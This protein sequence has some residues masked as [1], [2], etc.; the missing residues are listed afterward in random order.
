M[1]VLKLTEKDAI[2]I[3]EMH[4]LGVHQSDIAKAINGSQ[5][6]IAIFVKAFNGNLEKLSLLHENHQVLIKS[7][8]PFYNLKV[9]QQSN[10]NTYVCELFFGLIKLKFK[11]E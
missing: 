6:F 1:K 7:I 4:R 2:K 8:S 5:S 11:P 3:M 9:K 10:N